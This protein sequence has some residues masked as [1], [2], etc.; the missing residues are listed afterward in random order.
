MEARAQFVKPALDLVAQVLR[1]D[2]GKIWL[3]KVS[4][5]AEAS[6]AIALPPPPESENEEATF[7]PDSSHE[8]SL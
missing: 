6:G 5:L 7:F 4:L 8:I 3:L 2:Q 1:A